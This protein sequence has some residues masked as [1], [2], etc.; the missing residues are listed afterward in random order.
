MK[1]V[2]Q[3]APGIEIVGTFSP[4]FRPPTDADIR[5]AAEMIAESGAD[6][7]WVGLGM[8]K[9]ELWMARLCDHLPGVGIL[10]VGAAFDFLA[11][12]SAR[13]PV[14][15]QKDRPRMAPQIRPASRAPVAAL[16]REQP[17]LPLLLG[18]QIVQAR[19][20]NRRS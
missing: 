4:P 8:P 18:R 11:G 10:G 13:A 5:T 9:Q 6:L 1:N 19:Y 14:W 17:D 7:V 15:M 12:T 2:Q 20:R 16:R 3:L